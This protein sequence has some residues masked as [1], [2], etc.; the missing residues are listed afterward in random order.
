M[1]TFAY[2]CQAHIIRITSGKVTLRRR[3][4]R[5]GCAAAAGAAALGWLHSSLPAN[6]ALTC[7]S[8]SKAYGAPGLR[9]GW[10]TVSDP[11]L[12][13]SNSGWRSSTPRSAAGL[14]SAASSTGWPN[15]GR[16]LPLGHHP[17][18]RRPRL[19]GVRF[20]RGGGPGGRPGRGGVGSRGL[21]RQLRR[22]PAEHGAEGR[23]P[24]AALMAATGNDHERHVRHPGLQQLLEV[25]RGADILFVLE[26]GREIGR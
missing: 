18:M 17:G 10:L 22:H 2:F 9:I 8:L 13:E 16:W 4:T 24:Y 26:A 5:A 11:R 20:L 23:A 25:R 3:M 15:A 6:R 21:L 19:G 12:R 1:D 7:A 14:S